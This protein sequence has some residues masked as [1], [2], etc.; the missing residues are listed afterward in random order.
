MLLVHYQLCFI[1][2]RRVEKPDPGMLA[3][4]LLAGL[5]AITAPCAFVKLYKFCYN[6]CIAGVLVILV[7]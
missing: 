1:C 6:W 7:I 3:N 2:M 5:V 4:G